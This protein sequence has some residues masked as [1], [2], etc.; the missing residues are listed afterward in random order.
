MEKEMERELLEIRLNTEYLMVIGK[1]MILLH[2]MKLSDLT[3]YL[4][5]KNKFAVIFKSFI[6]LI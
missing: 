6:Y 1:I 2:W 3:L 5:F 4:N